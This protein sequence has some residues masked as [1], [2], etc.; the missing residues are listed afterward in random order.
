MEQKSY[1]V[2]LT[3]HTFSKFAD[4]IEYPNYT[5][6]NNQE[7]IVL[8]DNDDFFLFSTQLEPQLKFPQNYFAITKNGYFMH[9]FH[10]YGQISPKFYIS[11]FNDNIPIK[12]DGFCKI[13]K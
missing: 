1:K 2:I 11:R 5:K 3:K 9:R 4:I 8:N 7:L 12:Y 13:V 10:L 6:I